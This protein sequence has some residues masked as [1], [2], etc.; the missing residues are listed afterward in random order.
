[1][2]G[3]WLPDDCQVGEMEPGDYCLWT[4]GSD[5]ERAAWLW[6]VCTPDG[7]RFSLAMPHLPDKEGRHHHVEIHEDHTVSVAPTPIQDRNSIMSPKGW[8]G[9]LRHGVWE[10]IE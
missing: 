8:H 7:C 3:R 9:Y 6:M 1:M 2:Q 4:Q 5:R 10:Q